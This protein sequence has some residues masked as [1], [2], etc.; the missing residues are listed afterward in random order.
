MHS[1]TSNTNQVP[2][3]RSYLMT[4]ERVAKNKTADIKVMNS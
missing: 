4:P 2:E 1:V 3:E